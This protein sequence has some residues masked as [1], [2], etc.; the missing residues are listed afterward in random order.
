MPISTH[1]LDTSLGVP[2]RG[3]L[4]RLERCGSTRQDF[5][6]ENELEWI[7]CGE[8]YTNEDGR[9][10]NISKH[11]DLSAGVYRCLFFTSVYFESSETPYF[12]PRI[13]VMFKVHDTSEHY[14]IPLLLS[15]F[16]YTTYRGS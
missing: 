16:G 2:V 13:E 10:P 11:I 8:E 7:I 14:H 6:T 12:H 4:V 3:I 9:T 15:P 1:I 5:G